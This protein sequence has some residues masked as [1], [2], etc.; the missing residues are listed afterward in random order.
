MAITRTYN[1][2]VSKIVGIE[3]GPLGVMSLKN[4]NNINNF[5]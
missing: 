4:N 1:F 3:N 5:K 2:K